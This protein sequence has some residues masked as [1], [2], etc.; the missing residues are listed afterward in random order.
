MPRPKA[1]HSPTKDVFLAGKLLG[2]AL[3]INTD[4]LE[5]YVN[6]V[7]DDQFSYKDLCRHVIAFCKAVKNHT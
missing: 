3:Q 1:I 7:G 5:K 6:E 4:A 2:T